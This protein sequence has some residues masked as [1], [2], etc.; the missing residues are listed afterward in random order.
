VFAPSFRHPIQSNNFQ[1]VLGVKFS[2]LRHFAGAQR[3]APNRRV[4]N[5]GAGSP[6][7]FSKNSCAPEMNFEYLV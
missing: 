2:L 4:S 6:K 3:Y 7:D 5:F 1:R